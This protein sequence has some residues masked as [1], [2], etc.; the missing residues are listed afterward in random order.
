MFGKTSYNVQSANCLNNNSIHLLKGVYRT[1]KVSSLISRC[2]KC[3]KLVSN[4]VSHEE[5]VKEQLNAEER[6]RINAKLKNCRDVYTL[7][8][9]LRFEWAMLDCSNICQAALIA[10]QLLQ[11]RKLVRKVRA[12]FESLYKDLL[13]LIKDRYL[14]MKATGI[15]DCLWSLGKSVQLLSINENPQLKPRFMYVYEHLCIRAQEQRNNMNASDLSRV[16]WSMGAVRWNERARFDQLVQSAIDRQNQLQFHSADIV[17]LLQGLEGIGNNDHQQ[18]KFVTKIMK[19]ILNTSEMRPSHVSAA[20]TSL[21]N[22]RFR[23]P[24][25]ISAVSESIV[26]EQLKFNSCMDI[27]NLMLG[28]AQLGLIDR[29]VLNIII[30]QYNRL[31]L[32]TTFSFQSFVD[33]LNALSIVKAP[34]TSTQSIIS[35]ADK[36]IQTMTFK[37]YESQMLECYQLA[38]LRQ[39]QF[40][41]RSRGHQLQYTK[42]MQRACTDGNK[43]CIQDQVR[44]LQQNEFLKQVYEYIQS[45]FPQ[46]ECL[47]IIAQGEVL[48]HILVKRSDRRKIG[49]KG[50]DKLVLHV[51]FVEDYTATFPRRLLGWTRQKR[52]ILRGY[53]CEVE[54][55][56]QLEWQLDVNYKNKIVDRINKILKQGQ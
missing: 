49:K 17:N 13:D 51:C 42:R 33:M 38:S 1:R 39:A 45:K 44:I 20:M 10:G 23:D 26:F 2:R 21:K 43:T 11:Q 54:N 36:G 12:V 19:Q 55:V 31:L 22:L 35:H 7:C 6:L 28:Y 4:T 48:T 52:A 37:P 53:R 47:K 40:A 18:I 16:I 24:D 29:R 25:L 32:S 56:S 30:Q 50:S 27:S 14:E 9:A 15:A 3:Y 8:S 34:I 41:F 46:A 5:L